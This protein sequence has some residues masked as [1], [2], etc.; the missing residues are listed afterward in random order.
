MRRSETSI[1]KGLREICEYLNY[2]HS[3][4]EHDQMEKTEEYQVVVRASKTLNKVSNRFRLPCICKET[5]KKGS[6]KHT[7]HKFLKVKR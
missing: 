3:L 4:P 7:G 1:C 5:T 6:A 2:A